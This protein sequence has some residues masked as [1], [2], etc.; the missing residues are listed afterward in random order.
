MKLTHI[1]TSILKTLYEIRVNRNHNLNF[2]SSIETE[3]K[4]IIN[5]KQEI[6]YYIN[7][8]I[9]KGYIEVTGEFYIGKE[10]INQKYNN[11]AVILR[12]QHLELTL[13]GEEVVE[14]MLQSISEK[15][16]VF[17]TEFAKNVN[18]SLRNKIIERISDVVLIIISVIITLIVQK[19]YF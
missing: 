19:Y 2:F 17:T 7:R 14:K 11:N 12:E 1:E 18:E 9:K 16:I 8:L 6:V 13:D 10:E 5:K 3:E 15:T 4:S